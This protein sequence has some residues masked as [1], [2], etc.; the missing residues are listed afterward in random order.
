MSKNNKRKTNA[1]LNIVKAKPV[2]QFDKSVIFKEFKPNSSEAL[3]RQIILNEGSI[4]S[5]KL[6]FAEYEKILPA[7]I[8]AL[9]FCG[10]RVQLKIGQGAPYLIQ[11]KIIGQKD[12]LLWKD[13][14]LKTYEKFFPSLPVHVKDDGS[15]ITILTSLEKIPEV[16][17]D[18]LEKANN[19]LAII[20]SD[21]CAVE[22]LL[23][24]DVF[25]LNLIQIA[26]PVSRPNEDEKRLCEDIETLL[27]ALTATDLRVDVIVSGIK[28][29]FWEKCMFDHTWSSGVSVKV[30]SYIEEVDRYAIKIKKLF[31]LKD[32]VKASD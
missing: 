31:E 2:T 16:P 4:F 19:N 25:K 23:G 13:V 18:K 30:E 24:M 32:E 15:I 12:R 5:E 22:I 9:V 20:F 7:S 21:C 10:R 17:V 28:K 8:L 27:D 26:C 3:L 14:I 6:V 11:L 29:E 1:I